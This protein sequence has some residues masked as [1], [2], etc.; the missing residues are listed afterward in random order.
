[1]M[2]TRVPTR[3]SAEGN[4]GS[5]CGGGGS[6]S[7]DGRRSRR[8][9]S[10]K[11]A[12]GRLEFGVGAAQSVEEIRSPPPPPPRL[13]K[14]DSIK[15]SIENTNTCTDSLVTAF[16]DETLLITDYIPNDMNTKEGVESDQ[17]SFILSFYYKF[18]YIA[19]SV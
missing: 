17:S 7:G 1:M 2:R 9:P 5:I 15:I 18:I 19:Y 12:N 10:L 3:N 11:L 13:A 16:D 8:V 4:G 14:D 6:S